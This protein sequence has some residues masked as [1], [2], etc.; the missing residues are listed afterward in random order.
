MGEIKNQAHTQVIKKKNP[1]FFPLLISVGRSLLQNRAVECK[2]RVPLCQMP[3]LGPV[4][5]RAHSGLSS[6]REGN[7]PA[8]TAAQREDVLGPY[9]LAMAKGFSTSILP[10]SATVTSFKG[11]S[12][13]SVLVL[14]TFRT[15]S[16]KERWKQ[17]G[18]VGQEVRQPKVYGLGRMRFPPNPHV[19]NST[20]AWRHQNPNGILARWQPRAVRTQL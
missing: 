9:S 3:A 5:H 1:T 8:Q 11:L 17:E 16:W 6:P 19:M 20:Q 14:S 2:G 7:R 18:R 13:P 4:Q 10:Q 15:T 12:R